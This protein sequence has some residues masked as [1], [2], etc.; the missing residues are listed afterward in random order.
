MSTAVDL[1][2]AGDEVRGRWRP[3]RSISLCVGIYALCSIAV[4]WNLLASH[5]TTSSICGCGDP[6]RYL[7]FVEYPAW[8]ISHGA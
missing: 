1:D 4:L 8:A 3:A 7:W 2:A 5:P 6:A